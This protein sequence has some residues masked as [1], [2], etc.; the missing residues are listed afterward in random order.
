MSEKV[1]PK[2]IGWHALIGLSLKDFFKES[3]FE[4]D[5]EKNLAVKS[6]YVDILIISKSSGK[7]LDKL[8][9]GFEFLKDYNILT[10][11]SLKESLNQWAM[12]EILGHYVSYRKIISPKDK[13]LPESQFQVFA[14]CTTYPQKILG[15][16]KNFGK[17][18]EKIKAGVY[19]IESPLT[20]SLV[21][22]VLS[23]MAQLWQL[24]S[25]NAVGFEYGDAHYKWHEPENKSLLNRLY[26]LY[27][28]E[29]VDMPYTFEEVHREYT[30]PLIESLPTEM[31]LKGIPPE[32]RL[33]GLAPSERLKGLTPSEIEDYLLKLKNN[34][35]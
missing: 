15:S 2:K 11:K 26:Q 21:I 34:T 6:Q 27:L 1:K 17:E 23:Q 8:P 33:K 22:L 7:Q 25:G 16:E 18:I 29:D 35:H 24:F 19:K 5:T 14:I 12:V 28:K 13:L 3:N 9:D 30:M 31:R 10:Y 32:E 20:G 4:V